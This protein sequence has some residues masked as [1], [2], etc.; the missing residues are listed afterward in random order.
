MTARCEHCFLNNCPAHI[1]GMCDVPPVRQE[2][3]R[4]LPEPKKINI[5]SGED[6]YATEV[7]TYMMCSHA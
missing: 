2:S 3:A 5:A 7:A 6:A 4:Q 1:K